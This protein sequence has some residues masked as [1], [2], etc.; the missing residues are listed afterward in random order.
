MFHSPSALWLAL[1]AV[2]ACS[3]ATAQSGS[4]APPPPAAPPAFQSALQGYR[5]FADEKVAPWAQSN[6]TVGKPAAPPSGTAAP[7][8]GH[9][10]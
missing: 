5:S 7:H 4:T 1:A 6:T 9:K 2:G 3:A 10:H 8:G